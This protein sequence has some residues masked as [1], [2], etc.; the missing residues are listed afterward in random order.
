MKDPSFNREH[1]RKNSINIDT[2]PFFVKFLSFHQK[3][4]EQNQISLRKWGSNEMIV[5]LGR[6]RGSRVAHMGSISKGRCRFF[7]AN[8]FYISHPILFTLFIDMKLSISPLVFFLPFYITLL[9][10]KFINKITKNSLYIFI[11]IIQYYDFSIY[12]SNL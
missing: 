9:F 1:K 3:T 6:S 2:Q 12:F 5:W 11:L 10:F 8:K 7:S 4:R